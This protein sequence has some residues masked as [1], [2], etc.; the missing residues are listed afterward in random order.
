M[1]TAELVEV[2]EFLSHRKIPLAYSVNLVCSVAGVK[3]Q[4]LAVEAGV[5][6]NHLYQMLRGTRPV[7]VIM[8][9]TFERRLGLDPWAIN[10]LKSG[11]RT[12]EEN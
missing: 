12:N 3:L 11:A 10:D 7:S 2:L 5:G 4:E 1:N 8:R 9:L 6:R